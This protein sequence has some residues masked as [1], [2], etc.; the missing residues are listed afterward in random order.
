MQQDNG[1][2]KKTVGRFMLLARIAI[3]ILAIMSLV[4]ISIKIFN[5]RFSGINL[6]KNDTV[7]IQKFLYC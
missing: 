4:F 5:I 6:P 1:K 2:N 3:I 7:V